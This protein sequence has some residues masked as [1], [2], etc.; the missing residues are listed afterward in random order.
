MLVSLSFI[1]TFLAAM[2]LGVV[3]DLFG[4][5]HHRAWTWMITVLVTI[6]AS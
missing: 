5:G 6:V 4:R 3:G 2:V 1:G